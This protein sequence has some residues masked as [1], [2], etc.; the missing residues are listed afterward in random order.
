VLVV[1]D[2]PSLRE[3]VVDLLRFEGYD[4]REAA[5]GLAALTLLEGW[6]PDTIV[7]DLMMPVMDGW[8]FAQAAHRRLSPDSVPILIASA[9]PDL[10]NAARDLRPYGVRAAVAKPF[11]VDVLLAAIEH[12]VAR[13]T[14][15]AWPT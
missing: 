8:T 2:E 4:V 5:N 10:S 3:V 7:L 14:I 13:T 6:R 11:D 1:E 12:L 15:D 9:S